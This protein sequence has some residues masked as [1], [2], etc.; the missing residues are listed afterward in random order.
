MLVWGGETASC[1][2]PLSEALPPCWEKQPVSTLF[3]DLSSFLADVLQ[4][5]KRVWGP[6]SGQSVKMEISFPRHQLNM[7]FELQNE[8]TWIS[9]WP[10]PEG[11]LIGSRANGARRD[12]RVQCV[13]SFLF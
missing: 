3:R 6:L 13:S 5:G 4:P 1:V 10:R 9:V 7:A 2:S 8:T 12:L 11:V